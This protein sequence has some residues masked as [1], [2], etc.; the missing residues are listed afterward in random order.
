MFG[1]SRPFALNKTAE[2]LPFTFLKKSGFVNGATR[3]HRDH[4]LPPNPHF[5]ECPV[6]EKFQLLSIGRSKTKIARIPLGQSAK[7]AF[8]SSSSLQCLSMPLNS[9]ADLLTLRLAFGVHVA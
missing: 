3:S 4:A 7:L 6:V 5:H 8:S 2:H 1:T 9:T